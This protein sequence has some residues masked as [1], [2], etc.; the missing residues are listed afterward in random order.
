MRMVL[1][2]AAGRRTPSVACV[3]QPGSSGFQKV[4]FGNEEIAIPVA[5]RLV[6]LDGMSD[7]WGVHRHAASEAMVCGVHSLQSCGIIQC[8][9]VCSTADA[10]RA[11][12]KADVFIN[13]ASMRR[14]AE[15]CTVPQ[16]VSSPCLLAHS[17]QPCR[18]QPNPT[19]G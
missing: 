19:K 14:S 16:R 10:V 4:F 18:T 11:H 15:H 9:N 7:S 5:S 13:F 6:S 17:S 12:P 3:V 2:A 8:V 1:P